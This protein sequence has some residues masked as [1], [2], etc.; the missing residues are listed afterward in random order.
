MIR[1]LAAGVLALAAVSCAP[2]C[3]DLPVAPQSVCRLADA[4]VI[5]AGAP[6]VV[7]AQTT[8]RTTCSVSVDGGLVS[9]TFTGRTCSSNGANG[10]ADPI[11]PGP[12]PCEVPALAAGTYRFN[13]STPVTFTIPESADAG[14]P[15]CP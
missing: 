14:V 1:A 2:Q 15:L 6:F 3:D 7:Q 12:Q 13:S 11:A 5:A 9:L 10:F 8:L 4:G